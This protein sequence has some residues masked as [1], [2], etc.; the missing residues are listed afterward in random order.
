MS[1]DQSALDDLRRSMA[2][3]GYHLELD[4]S[5]SGVEVRITAGPDACAECLVPKPLMLG[6]LQSELGMPEDA[7]TL[8]YPAG[9]D[10]DARAGQE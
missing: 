10:G 7:I 2:A 1:I 4:E 6:L 9:A 5:G 3:D 8:I